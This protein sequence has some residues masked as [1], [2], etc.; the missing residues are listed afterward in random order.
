MRDLELLM[1]DHERILDAWAEGGVE[2]L[3]GRPTGVQRRHPREG[4]AAR[5]RPHRRR[6]RGSR[7]GRRPTGRGVRPGSEGVRALRRR[8][9]PAPGA[10]PAGTAGPARQDPA[11]GQG[12]G[13]VRLHHLRRQ[14]R[15]PGR[16]WP[17]LRGREE[18]AGAPGAGRGYARAVPGRRRGDH[19]RAGVGI[20]DRSPSHEPALL[21]LRRPSGKHGHAL[22]PARVRLRRPRR[23]PGPP[24]RPAARPRP[25][26]GP[27]ARGRGP[28]RG[29]T[30]CSGPT[31]T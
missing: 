9:A 27:P 30:A 7:N 29:G 20:R 6:R 17:P 15:R 14:Q 11:C 8:A 31:P 13:A 21:H 22:L 5:G 3:G 2:A 24:V 12:P 19:G 25:E 23:G 4:G 10:G 26:T 18:H 28:A 16:G 1:N